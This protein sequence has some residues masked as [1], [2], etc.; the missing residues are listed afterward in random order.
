MLHIET[1]SPFTPLGSKG[2]GEG[3]CMSTP[4][5]LANAVADALGVES[6]D[7]PL[8]PAKLAAHV[9]G[10]ERP[11]PADRPL[12]RLR[13]AG[14]RGLTGDGE[15]RVPAPPEAIWAMLLDADTLA[16]I[17]PGAHSVEK[18]SDTRFRADVTLGV[19]PVKG[20]YKAEITLSDLDPPRAA[21]LAGS[22]VGALG[23]G[24]GSGRITLA[25]DEGGTRVSYRY[26]AA[27]GGK[28]AAVGD[29]LLSGAARVVIGGFFTALG[30]KA[31]GRQE[32]G[33]LSRLR[34][35]FGRRA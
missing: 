20:R 29:R 1:K 32:R 31:G 35:L 18:L 23:S 3:N 22:V 15:A 7:L 24:A 27:V 4:V 25:P 30:R 28:V 6:I 34:A 14:E 10:E 5:C 12:A 21:T 16:S 26:E 17:I 9:H 13:K 2:V 11:A 33:L 8:T 19:G